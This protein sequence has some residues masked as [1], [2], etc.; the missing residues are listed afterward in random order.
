MVVVVV[1]ICDRGGGIPHANMARVW[2]Y[3]FTTS[4]ED[5]ETDNMMDGGL[6]ATFT[7]NRAAGAMHGYV[8]HPAAPGAGEEANSS[9]CLN[10][11]TL[12][13]PKTRLTNLMIFF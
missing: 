12:R 3:G 1:R 11:F 4:G 7:E 2:D 9:S 6:F 10:P 5:R 8:Y 13:A